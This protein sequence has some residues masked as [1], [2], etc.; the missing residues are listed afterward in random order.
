MVTDIHEMLKSGGA[1][2]VTISG[3]AEDEIV[4]KLRRPSLFN[5]AAAGH[6]PNPLI[7]AAEGLFMANQN[8]IRQASVEDTGKVLILIAREAMTEPT[9]EQ[10]QEAGLEL[11]D[12]QLSEIYA[13]VIGGAARLEAFRHKQRG[14]AG[15]DDTDHALQGVGAAG[16]D[17]RVRGVVPGRSG[18][19]YRSGA[20][21]RKKAETQKDKGQPDAD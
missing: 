8:A 12:G 3:W 4:V 7:K 21:G 15:G 19:D 10:L 11:T 16:A 2:E 17:G 1:Q 20:E 9:Y 5:L 13:Y 14:T 6:I 18:G